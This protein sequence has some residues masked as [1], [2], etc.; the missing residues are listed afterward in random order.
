MANVITLVSAK[1][2]GVLTSDWVV[3]PVF[4]SNGIQQYTICQGIPTTGTYANKVVAAYF[5]DSNYE[6]AVLEK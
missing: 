3:L 1:T 2:S 4:A 6:M 5:T